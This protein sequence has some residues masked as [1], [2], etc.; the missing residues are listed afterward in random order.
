MKKKTGQTNISKKLHKAYW[1]GVTDA[2]C[3]IGLAVTF[4]LMFVY[5]FFR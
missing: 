4:G 5:G 1:R 3:G 2:I